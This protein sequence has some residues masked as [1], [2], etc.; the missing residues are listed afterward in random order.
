MNSVKNSLVSVCLA[1]Y[2][3]EKYIQEQLDSILSQ[4]YPNIEI[5]IQDD[6]STDQ[7][8]TILQTYKNSNIKL[9][10][11][12]NNL[13][14]QKNFESLLQKANGN[15]IALCDQDDIWQENKIELLLNNI[16][17]SSLIYSDSLLVD[18]NNNS[19]EKKLSQQLKNNFITSHSALEFVYDNSVSA[20]A[21][22]F[23]KELL[24]YI[25]FFPQHIYFD[26]YIAATAASL[27]GINYYDMPLVRYR[28]HSTNTL[29]KKKHKKV[30]LLKQISHKLSKK[31]KQNR[32][33]CNEL[34]EFL[35]IATLC[36]NEKK[37]LNKLYNIH[38]DFPNT[39]FNIKTF[40]FFFQHKHQLFKITT[41]D[42]NILCIKK[43]IGY[44]L[45]KAF[46][47]L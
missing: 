21:M 24:Q 7:T 43:S 19:L 28:Q 4:T 12:K 2:N 20:H 13:G 31:L 45:Y 44:K 14:Y 11:N 10:K 42:K 25:T 36:A 39:F 30:S 15:F 47:I 26:Q 5:I 22:L 40:I 46:P 32:E 34:Q 18:E 33:I 8:Y 17:E 9:F 1:T 6:A 23:K 29:A 41:R 16:G 38:T 37:L 27:H 3:G 35:T